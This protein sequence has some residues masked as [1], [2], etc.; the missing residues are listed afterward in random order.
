MKKRLEKI[1]ETNFRKPYVYYFLAIF[2]IYLLVN[3]FV[4]KIYV[5][6]P[7]LFSYNLKIIIPFLFLTVLIAFLVAVNINLIIFKFKEVRGI[8]KS[9][10]VGFLGIF[11]GLL[12]GG[13]PSCFVGLFPAFLGLFGVTASLSSLPFFGLEILFGSAVL[14]LISIYFLTRDNIC[15]I[16]LD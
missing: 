12:G 8:K 14:L 9:G 15:K 6:T 7:L 13:C 2:F 3:F 10:S 5:S 4:N 16:N 1:K 11:G